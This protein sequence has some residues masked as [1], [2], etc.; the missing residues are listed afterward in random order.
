MV[1]LYIVS[2]MINGQPFELYVNG[3]M[4]RFK[5]VEALSFISDRAE[6]EISVCI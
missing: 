5:C 4:T 3:H 6:N 1:K 2:V